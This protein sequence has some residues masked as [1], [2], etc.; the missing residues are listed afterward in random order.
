MSSPPL[1]PATQSVY[2]RTLGEMVAAIFDP[3]SVDCCFHVRDPLTNDTAQFSAHRKLLGLFSPA[4]ARLFAD[5]ALKSEP[6]VVEHVS[7]AAV[8]MF[9]RYFYEAS[10]ELTAELAGELLCLAVGYEVADLVDSCAHFLGRHVSCDNAL[11]LLEVAGRHNNERLAGACAKLIAANA[12]AVAGAPSFLRGSP[13]AV[14]RF[15]QLPKPCTATLLFDRCL[16]WAEGQQQAARDADAD[17]LAG[18]RAQLADCLK[19]LPFQQIGRDA[20]ID[21]FERL[22]RFVSADEANDILLSLLRSAVTRLFVVQR[23]GVGAGAAATEFK[24]ATHNTQAQVSNCIRFKLN[25]T[26][27]LQRICVS[28]GLRDGQP[29]AFSARITVKRGKSQLFCELHKFPADSVEFRFP[30]KILFEANVVYDVRVYR[31]APMMNVFM[32]SCRRQQVGDV[33]MVPISAGSADN[34]NVAGIL[35]SIAS[36]AFDEFVVEEV[37]A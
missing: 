4:L 17:Q 10:V 14:K 13:A 19:A 33:E 18:L 32:H 26:M 2:F 31:H 30:C 9:L 11:G 29:I 25:K 3:S 15:V 24:F 27:L 6:I 23:S 28:N 37:V 21:R 1:I 12:D 16:E 8:E 34:E 7:G 35:T 36:I 5:A 22:R 20:V